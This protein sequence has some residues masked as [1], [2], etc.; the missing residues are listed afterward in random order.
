MNS[1]GIRR[2]L[3]VVVP[4][5]IL[6]WLVPW[7]AGLFIVCGLID[8]AR[9]KRFDSALLAKYFSGNGM[10]TWVLS[11]IN[12]LFDLISKRH[13]YRMHLED[14]PTEERVEIENMLRVFDDRREEIMADMRQRME[15]KARGM[16]FYR[17]YDE[18]MDQSVPEFNR[19]FKYVKTIGVSLFNG[20]EK[21][22]LH[23]GPLRLTIRLLY[24][25]T[26]RQSEKVFI[27]VNGEK[28]FWHDDP[29][30][31]FDD[32]VQHRS[33]NGEDGLRACVFVDVL[34]PSAFTRL[35]NVVVKIFNLLLSGVN[36]IFYKNWDMLSKKPTEPASQS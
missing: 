17:W 22:S 34:R 3:R 32:T 28:H 2:T 11:P 9:H 26:P 12:L 19:N 21:T 4:L 1:K 8:V 15:G 14:F 23:F 24:N 7:I 30:F 33:V 5:A 35:Q 18:A 27:E 36:R 10:L 29:L 20:Q 25:L 6:F 31:I 13:H 16:V